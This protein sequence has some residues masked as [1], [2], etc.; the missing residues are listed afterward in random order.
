MAATEAADQAG[1]EYKWDVALSLLSQDLRYAKRLH[2]E[3]RRHIR[4]GIFLY[5]QQQ[6]E[7]AAAGEMSRFFT[8][9]FMEETRLAVILYRP[10]WGDRGYTKI[11]Q[12]AILNARLSQPD[13]FVF[14][15]R[16]DPP[17]LPSWYP[18]NNF[19]V[20]APAYS[21]PQVAAF[22]IGRASQLGGTMGEESPAELAARMAAE[23]KAREAQ[24][25]TFRRQATERAQQEAE[26]V[27]EELERLAAE[28]SEV[29][30]D[31][32]VA[33]QRRG[34]ECLL[35]YRRQELTVKWQPALVREMPVDEG[36]RLTV[37][38]FWGPSGFHGFT[39]R[40]PQTLRQLQYKVA[41]TLEGI[42][43]WANVKGTFTTS[44]SVAQEAMN[45]LVRQGQNPRQP[46]APWSV[47]KR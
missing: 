13:G 23:R 18:D 21:V 9:V 4:G 38:L 2:S 41:L 12:E 46:P 7:V 15:V 39:S 45:W 47:P 37:A 28:V 33:F 5:E 25:E 14:M 36:S 43:G 29:T 20:D 26:S 8:R 24:E 30:K 16:L 42:W 32:P 17:A 44:P 35:T 34:L 1:K 40:P 19:A 10:G 3:L 31:D 27:I 22:I 6:Q 11:E